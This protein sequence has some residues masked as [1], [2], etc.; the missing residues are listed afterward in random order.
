MTYTYTYTVLE[1]SPA[2]YDEISRRLRAA[3]QEGADD[4]RGLVDM[5]GLALRAMPQRA[6][7]RVHGIRNCARCGGEHAVLEFGELSR[8]TSHGH[9]HW[10]PCPT[11]GE[12]I[13]LRRREIAI[14][15]TA[16]MEG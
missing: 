4:E 2:V 13:L 11:N 12:P 10:A 3:G 9:T 5:H 8:P 14:K 6:P 15:P 1:V 7:V 16:E